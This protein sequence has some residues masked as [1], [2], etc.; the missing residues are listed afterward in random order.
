MPGRETRITIRLDDPEMLS[1]GIFALGFA[2]GESSVR[3]NWGDGCIE[4]VTADKR[5][6]HTYAALGTYTVTLSDTIASLKCSTMNASDYFGSPSAL[7]ILAFSTNAAKLRLIDKWCFYRAENMTEFICADSGIQEMSTQSFYKC[8][9]LGGSLNL[10]P[11]FSL[12][13][14]TFS[15]CEGITE[16]VFDMANYETITSNPSYD[17]KFGAKNANIRFE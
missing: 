6:G 8:Y 11:V 2:D 7:R 14:T 12:T 5:I 15:T 1:W 13:N 9:A 3:I 10:K 4:T 16:I 17:V